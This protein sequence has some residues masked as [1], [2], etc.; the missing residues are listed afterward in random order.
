LREG[1]P[2][3][4]MIMLID[5][6]GERYGQ[7]PSQVI[8]TATTFDVFVA[9]TAIGYRNLQ[10]ARANDPNAVPEYQQEDLLKMMEQARAIKN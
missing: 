6:I 3:L 1:S 9:D 7:L 5:T 10:Q 4:A 8:R 2:E